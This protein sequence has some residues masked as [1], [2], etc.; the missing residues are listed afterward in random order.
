MAFAI[1]AGATAELAAAC[2]RRAVGATAAVTAAVVGSIVHS[3][4]PSCTT[5]VS[6]GVTY[7]HCGDTWYQP[8]YAGTEL[9][10]VVVNPP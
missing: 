10:Y 7:Q 1:A 3:L 5:V 8:R 4:P 9:S 2:S 6:G